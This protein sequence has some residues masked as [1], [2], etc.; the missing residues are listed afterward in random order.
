MIHV[1]DCVYDT[2]RPR[3]PGGARGNPAFRPCRGPLPRLAADPLGTTQ[4][5][6]GL[7]RRGAHRAPPAA[8]LVDP[9]RRGGR[10]ARPAHAAWGRR[11][12]RPRPRRPG[13][14]RRPAQGRA[15]PDAR[16]LPAAARRAPRHE[17]AAEAAVAA[18][19]IPDRAARRAHGRGRARPRD[20]RAARGHEGPRHALA[21]RGGFPGG[22]ARM[23][24]ARREETRE[25]LGP[26]GREAPAARGRPLL[27]RPGARGLRA[28]RHRGAGLPRD[29]PRDAA[30]DGRGR[31]RHHAAAAPRGGR[32]IRL[33]AKPRRAALRAAGPEP[34]DWR[35]L[36][37]L[38]LAPARDP[39][40][41]RHRGA[42]RLNRARPAAFARA[43]RAPRVLSSAAMRV[44][45][46]A[47]TAIVALVA[48]SPGPAGDALPRL[49]VLPGSLTVSGVSSG[50]YM[51]TQ[52]QV[53]YS[54]DV[55]GAGIVAA[56]PWLCAQGI[57]T[58]AP[59]DCLAGETGG[60][61]VTPLVAA[62]RASAALGAV[63]DPSGLAADRIWI[64]HGAKDDVVG[65]AVSDSLLR[66]YKAF[67]PVERIRYETQ[68][69]AGHGFPTPAE[70]GDCG[71]GESPWILACGYDAAGE[72]L[73]H[74][75]D[76][77]AAPSGSVT[78]SEERRVGK[79]GGSG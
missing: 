4:E 19:R 50:G 74:L 30:A 46:I 54:D 76:G 71:A 24:P 28:R 21:V 55:A 66:F 78:R 64:F 57:V 15:D 63:D 10:P 65:A 14:A 26:R 11:H 36:A 39:G 27:A 70:G 62:L 16:P 77:L 12:P 53:A 43:R 34:G 8:G 37:A 18:A 48:C 32:P 40:G 13:P 35:R 45:A 25:I 9:S 1:I 42:R 2:A 29:Q 23:P 61:D 33:R 20:P 69:P 56:G 58:R 73:N 60:P 3:I 72:M 41:L 49:N 59:K 31:A 75:Y 47:L 5:A 67:V 22:R 44:P 51:A 79:E 68:V 7:A 38:Q 52:Y 17:G 6:R